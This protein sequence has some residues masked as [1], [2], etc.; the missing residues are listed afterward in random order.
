MPAEAA[1]LA[2]EEVANVALC[3]GGSSFAAFCGKAPVQVLIEEARESADAFGAAGEDDDA[4]GLAVET[5]GECR[6]TVG[7]RFLQIHASSAGPVDAGMQEV[8]DRFASDVQV[9][10]RGH[11]QPGVVGQER[12][13]AGDVVVGIG[14][15][16][17]PSEFGL[18]PY[19][20]AA[21]RSGAVS[22]LWP[23]PAAADPSLR[24]RLRRS[25]LPRPEE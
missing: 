1:G 13:H 3:V 10:S 9:G 19:A 18:F 23:E 20:E 15:R 22:P 12:N 2:A 25:S 7:A 14:L 21:A 6:L 5:N 24:S 11:G 8:G 16:E 4:C 17:R